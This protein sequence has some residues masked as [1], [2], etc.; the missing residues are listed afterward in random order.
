MGCHPEGGGLWQRQGYRVMNETTLPAYFPA[1]LPVTGSRPSLM[2]HPPHFLWKSLC[3]VY[4][5]GLS[6]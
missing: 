1:P 3:F 6:S 4:A 5:L 2:K